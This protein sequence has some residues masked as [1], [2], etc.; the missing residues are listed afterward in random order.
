MG[1]AGVDGYHNAKMDQKEI[2][3]EEFNWLHLVRDRI[4]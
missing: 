3:T 1:V 2:M 4:Q